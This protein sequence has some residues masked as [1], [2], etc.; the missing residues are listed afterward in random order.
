VVLRSLGFKLQSIGP[1]WR[2]GRRR[3]R[4]K[5]ID[6]A[7]LLNASFASGNLLGIP[8]A[9]AQ[10]TDTA[11]AFSGGLKNT[12]SY[13]TMVAPAIGLETVSEATLLCWVKRDGAQTDYTPMMVNRSDKGVFTGLTFVHGNAL[14]YS[15]GSQPAAWSFN[16]GLTR[17][18]AAVLCSLVSNRLKPYFT[19]QRG[20]RFAARS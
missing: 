11:V 9:I 17:A 12:E 1:Y 6:Y 16:S 10:D 5:A 8:G 13:S 18:D 7:H 19:W 15:W 4:D 14:G 2:F 3:W 20:D